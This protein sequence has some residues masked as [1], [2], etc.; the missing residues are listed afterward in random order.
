VRT[1]VAELPLPQRRALE[2]VF[3]EGL[4]HAGTAARLGIPLGTAK[5]RIRAA[6]HQLAD[7]LGPTVLGPG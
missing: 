1:A 2:L 4:T 3:Y 6:L 7:V 5:T